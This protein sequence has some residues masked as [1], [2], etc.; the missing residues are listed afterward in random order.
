MAAITLQGVLTAPI[1]YCQKLAK[2]LFIYVLFPFHPLLHFVLTHFLPSRPKSSILGGGSLC[3]LALLQILHCHETGA[4]TATA[5]AAA[6]LASYVSLFSDHGKGTF[7]SWP[8]T[9]L[10][11]IVAVIVLRTHYILWKSKNWCMNCSYELPA[12]EPLFELVKIICIFPTA[13]NLLFFLLIY[14]YLNHV[15]GVKMAFSSCQRTFICM[16]GLN[17]YLLWKFR[18]DS[19]ESIFEAKFQPNFFILS[20]ILAEYNICFP[21]CNTFICPFLLR[22]I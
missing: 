3:R 16:M 13:L 4:A 14:I 5:E 22:E 8:P 9:L 7:A 15:Y 12:S 11:A 20:P 21:Y 1:D 17:H 6:K 10:K 18:L 19:I 2:L